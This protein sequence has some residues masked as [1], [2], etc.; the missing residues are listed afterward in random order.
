MKM[1][2]NNWLIATIQF[3]IL[4]INSLCSYSP[5]PRFAK[6]ACP[7]EIIFPRCAI[8]TQLSSLRFDAREHIQHICSSTSRLFGTMAIAC[9]VYCD[10]NT[11]LHRHS[12]ICGYTGYGMIFNGS[13]CF[14]F[15][16]LNR[17][18]VLGQQEKPATGLR[19]AIGL[20]WVFLKL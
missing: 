15:V 3:L 2:Q 8:I 5:N 17:P 20:S 1:S 11:G 9:G 6:V 7:T 14:F 18:L 19:G 12:G 4:Q 10:L 16:T 13:P